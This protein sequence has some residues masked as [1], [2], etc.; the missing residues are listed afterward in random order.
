MSRTRLIR[1][2]CCLALALGGWYSVRAQEKDKPGVSAA[3]SKRTVYVVKYGAARELAGALAQHFKGTAAV[4]A[5]PP[6]DRRWV[7]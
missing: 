2:A 4:Q 7:V 6:R 1:T 5:L 3:G